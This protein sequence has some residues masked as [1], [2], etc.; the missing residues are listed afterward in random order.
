MDRLSVKVQNILTIGFV[1]ALLVAI[2][3]IGYSSTTTLGEIF[4][5]YRGAA[6]QSVAVAGLKEGLF[7]ARM[8]NF[9]YRITP[10]A[11][12]EEEV[13]SNIRQIQEAE[14]KMRT[15]FAEQPDVLAKLEGIAAETTQYAAAFDKMAALYNSSDERAG[16]AR[17]LLD[18]ARKAVKEALN[19]AIAGGNTN[20]AFLLGGIQDNLLTGSEQY[21]T[22][23]VSGAPEMHDEAAKRIASALNAVNAIAPQPA[24]GMTEEKISAVKNSLSGYSAA[25]EG[26]SQM[27]LNA[28][29]SAPAPSTCSARKCRANTTRCSNRSS[30][31]RTNSVRAAPI[32][33]GTPSSWCCGYR[34]SRWWPAWRSVSAWRSCCRARSPEPLPS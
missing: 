1:L 12:Q 15:L 23:L 6:R 8:A 9:R 32:P 33:P 4:T 17:T 25:V 5:E 2:A 28:Q 31:G 16:V 20:T 26:L 11:S 10:E 24:T 3:Y 34:C 13:R 18:E 29:R 14:D 30:P 19:T 27:A 22:F 7:K 21:E